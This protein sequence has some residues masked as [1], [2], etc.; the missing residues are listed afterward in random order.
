[1]KETNKIVINVEVN[2]VDEN[3]KKAEK[4]VDLLKEAKTLAGELA[5]VN[6]NITL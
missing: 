4:L 1:M 5:L 6:F 3:I 2:N